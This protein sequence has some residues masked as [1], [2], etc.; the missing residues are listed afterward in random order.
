[1]ASTRTTRR[2]QGNPGARSGRP[3][4]MTRRWGL[5][6]AIITVGVLAGACAQAQPGGTVPTG[7]TGTGGTGGTGPWLTLLRTGGLAGVH[8]QV[9]VDASGHWTATDKAGRSRTGQLDQST[10]DGLRAL[11]ADPRLAAQASRSAGPSRCQDAFTYTL[12][13][14]GRRLSY[15]DCPADPDQP[16][17]WK[18]V[19][20]LVARSVLG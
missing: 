8:D 5:L 15:V 17:A 14:S 6:V 3:R 10:V 9:T 13:V 7:V 12:T 11:A 4:G 1:M 19:V 18:A 16:D 2:P 20:D